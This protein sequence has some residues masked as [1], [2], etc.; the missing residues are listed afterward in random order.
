[1]R[2]LD[3]AIEQGFDVRLIALPDGEDPDSFVRNRGPEAF[4]RAIEQA[5]TIIQFKIESFRKQGLLD[6]PAEKSQSIRS[7]I[8]TVAKIPDVLQH[9]FYMQQIADTLHLSYGQLS[10]IYDELGKVRHSNS[11]QG[12]NNTTIQ[13]NKSKICQRYLLK[14]LLIFLRHMLCRKRKKFY[15]WRLRMSHH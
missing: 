6:S 12:Q 14:N 10:H 4:R 11:R 9:D 15:D 7:L 3:L 2:G 13:K 8:D 1:M 5:W